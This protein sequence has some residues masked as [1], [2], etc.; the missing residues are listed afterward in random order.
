VAI[1]IRGTTPATT[2]TTANPISLTLTGTR[3]PQ[4]GDVLLIIHGN[5]FYA[6]T[7]MPTPTVSGSTSGVTAVT[8]GSADAGTNHGHIKTYTYVAGSTGDLTVSV[9]E[10][11]PGD[12]D[13]CLAV[14]VLS[15]VDTSTPT[16][17][18]AGGFN[19]SATTSHIS[20]SVSPTS[21][22]AYLICHD[23]T[24]GGSSAS[25]YTPPS[26]MTETYDAQAG[27]ISHTGAT[28][29]LSASGATGTKTFTPSGS[30]EYAAV[31]VAMRTASGGS[32]VN[33]SAGLTG[34][35]T[36]TAAAS[37]LIPGA[38]TLTGAGT[39][40]AAASVRIPGAASPAGAG[41]LTAAAS[42]R[43]PGIAALSGAGTITAAATVTVPGAAALTGAGTLS[44]AGTVLVSG[45]A[46]LAGVGVLTA[47]SG[48]AVSGSAA[49]TGV[50]TLTAAALVLVPGAAMLT[51]AAALTASSS[52]QV[53]GAAA[54]IGVGAL[55]A[56]VAGDCKVH[57]PNTGTVTYASGSTI[58]RPGTGTVEYCTCC[59]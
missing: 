44:A 23:N 47:N 20:P 3:Q 22:D 16:D 42:V 13:K 40:T 32:T 31:S 33:G 48:S 27:G 57:R 8:G 36:L 54:L 17:G 45:A 39:L 35:G 30:V 25:S 52:T 46:A 15:G 38:A 28:L 9:T 14:Y 49:M 56:N 2:I 24:G 21:S 59:T 34:A 1:A 51:G 29:Q 26:G 19:T 41:T 7:A 4:T 10:T 11:G 6:A 18:A 37:V 43:I 50:G 12:E 58:T 5:D 53:S 55:T